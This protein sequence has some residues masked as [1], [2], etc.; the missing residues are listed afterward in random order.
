MKLNKEL[1]NFQLKSRSKIE[2]LIYSRGF[3][4]NF[5][6]AGQVE[7]Y[8]VGKIEGSEVTIWIYNDELEV[9]SNDVHLLLEKPD[10]ESQESM[11]DFFLTELK[12]LKMD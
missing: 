12:N 2:R 5:S 7:N 9:R 3:N 8:L 11:L 6:L 10:F 4:V 1:N